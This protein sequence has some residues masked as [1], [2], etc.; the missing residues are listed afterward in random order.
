MASASSKSNSQ[1][2]TTP[3]RP[4]SLPEVNKEN[5]SITIDSITPEDMKFADFS[6]RETDVL[7]SLAIP[8]HLLYHWHRNRNGRLFTEL[9]NSKVENSTVRLA[10][11]EVGI[12]QRLF[13][14]ASK[15]VGKVQ[16]ARGRKR[17]EILCRVTHL[18]VKNGE[19]DSFDNLQKQA[20]ELEGKLIEKEQHAQ[21]L[22]AKV[23]EKDN[24]I[25]M[26]LE[27]MAMEVANYEECLEEATS[28]NY[29]NKGK[30]VHELSPR[31]LRRK[32]AACKTFI[33]QTIWFCETFGLIPEC[34]ELK[35]KATGSPVKMALSSST[36]PSPNTQASVEN[37]NKV[38]Q[39]LY[40]LDRFAVSDEAY[41][42]LSSASDLPPAHHIKRKRSAHSQYTGYLDN[43][44]GPT[45]QCRTQYENKS[46]EW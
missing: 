28:S 3:G 45:A 39:V 26:L 20:H 46:H 13:V 23:L 10:V 27:D 12:E 40:I 38:S 33:Q 36:T 15:L 44:W 4:R 17:E 9:V 16:K 18:F 32:L 11:G 14:Q 21:E 2:P 7:F 42:E 34:I 29:E 8:N 31:Q 37:H 30:Q 6:D 5:L 41:H 25:T 24:E 43:T 35:K 1:L 22:E 19:A